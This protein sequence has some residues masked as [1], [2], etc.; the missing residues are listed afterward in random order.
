MVD[1][2]DRQG[3]ADDETGDEELNDL[4]TYYESLIPDLPIDKLPMPPPPPRTEEKKPAE[5]NEENNSAENEPKIR[6][7]VEEKDDF[8]FYTD[9]ILGI[10]SKISNGCGAKKK[11]DKLVDDIKLNRVEQFYPT[12]GKVK[13]LFMRDDA[14]K[15]AKQQIYHEPKQGFDEHHKS[16][17]FTGRW[18]LHTDA[19]IKANMKRKKIAKAR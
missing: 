8:T 19:E 13:G 6:L 2:P 1:E 5:K 12:W 17:Q 11:I 10:T 16:K 15:F 4:L 9:T 7:T 18:R 3:R 14:A